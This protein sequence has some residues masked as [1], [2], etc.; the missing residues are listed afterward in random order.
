MNELYDSYQDKISSQRLQEDQTK[1]NNDMLE[2]REKIK[3]KKK[4]QEK[5][6]RELRALEKE[7]EK[8]DIKEYIKNIDEITILT[9]KAIK[10]L[11]YLKNVLPKR[12]VKS[13]ELKIIKEDIWGH[14]INNL[15][16]E[17]KNVR[18]STKYLSYIP[19]Q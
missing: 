12:K 16:S 4:E 11:E 17:E 5:E 3:N 2:L 14:V 10:N 9:N 15:F 18:I 7:L 8:G 13:K 19:V 6:K 1:E